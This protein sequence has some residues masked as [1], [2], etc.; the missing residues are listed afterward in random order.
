MQAIVPRICL[1]IVS[2]FNNKLRL[3]VSTSPQPHLGFLSLKVTAS[4]QTIKLNIFCKTLHTKLF[5][6]QSKITCFLHMFLSKT[7]TNKQWIQWR[8]D[9]QAIALL[10]KQMSHWTSIYT[11]HN[12][13][14]TFPTNQL[15][16]KIKLLIQILMNRY[17]IWKNLLNAVD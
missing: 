11:T 8:S 6:K 16:T 1:E 3:I 7:S 15:I 9:L 10:I 5:N 4:Y 12:F 13:C 2:L 17:R 14:N